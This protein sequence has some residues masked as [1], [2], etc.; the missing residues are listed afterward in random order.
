[1]LSQRNADTVNA[2]SVLSRSKPSAA[3]KSINSVGV[4]RADYRRLRGFAREYGVNYT[5]L[6]SAM[7]VAWEQLPDDSKVEAIKQAG[8]SSK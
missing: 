8:D 2:M 7:L 6:V 5:R 1:M 3:S 4:R